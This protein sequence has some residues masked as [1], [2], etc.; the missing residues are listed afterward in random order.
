[1][2][3]VLF[4]INGGAHGGMVNGK[5]YQPG[6]RSPFIPPGFYEGEY[7][8]KMAEEICKTTLLAENISPGPYSLSVGTQVNFV[9]KICRREGKKQE[10]ALIDIH[11]NAAGNKKKW[12]KGNGSVIWIS[13]R[14]SQKSKILASIMLKFLKEFSPQTQ[15][16][17][18]RGI[19]K[20]YYGM[21]HN[22]NCPAII[23]EMGF[24]T[25]QQDCE[26]LKNKYYSVSRAIFS[27][28]HNYQTEIMGE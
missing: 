8:R 4:L 10:I 3:Q 6:K 5:Y 26:K 1:M 22:T 12:Y 13:H 9:N 18:S 21:V 27:G 2:N 19:K 25:N 16:S 20:C 15:I 24:H 17:T 28:L 23:L 14:A 11:T 7:C